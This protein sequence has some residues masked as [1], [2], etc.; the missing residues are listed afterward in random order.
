ME[1]RYAVR[2][3]G[4]GATRKILKPVFSWIRKPNEVTNNQIAW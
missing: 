1:T 2:R 3:K 4:L